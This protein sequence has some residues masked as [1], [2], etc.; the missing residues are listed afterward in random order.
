MGL[1]WHG[2]TSADRPPSFSGLELFLAVKRIT[3]MVNSM[4]Q[5]QML[6]DSSAAMESFVGVIKETEELL[7]AGGGSSARAD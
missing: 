1:R 3:A 6:M 2:D 7:T 5:R 4:E